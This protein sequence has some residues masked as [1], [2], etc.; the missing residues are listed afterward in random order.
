MKLRLF[1]TPSTAVLLLGLCAALFWGTTLVAG[2]P[3][4]LLPLPFAIFYS[5]LFAVSG[6]ALSRILAIER[7]SSWPGPRRLLIL[8]PHEDDCVISAGG[9]GLVNHRLGGATRIVYIAR[10]EAPGLPERRAREARTAWREAGIDDDALYT[11]DLLP[12]LM[13]R[14]P[15]RLHAAARTLREMIDEFGPE[16]VIVPMFEGGHV[17]HDMAASIIREIRTPQDRF[18]V[19]EAPEYSPYVSFRNTPHR[20]I[21][22]CAR[23]LFGLVSYYGPPDGIDGRPILKFRFSTEEI[24]T[25]RRM[26]GAFLSQNA[27]SLMETRSYPDRLVRVEADSRQSGRPFDPDNAYARLARELR[28]LLPP[29]LAERILPVPAG[30]IGR[31]DEV[32]VW[33]KEWEI[34]APR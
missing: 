11:L 13:Q 5:V 28:R 12:P 7:W 31:G 20:L 21:T 15:Q 23:W 10:D 34:G 26:L 16:A 24:A 3:L 27:P 30:T 19:F 25:K 32:T 6:W 29:R 18:E 2:W 1:F 8:A 14:D 9:I 17:H 22:L 4:G 33:S